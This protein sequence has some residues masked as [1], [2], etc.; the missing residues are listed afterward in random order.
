MATMKM[1]I[2]VDTGVDDA[3]AIM[4]ALSRP[5][6]EVVAITCVNGNVAID[7]VCRN[8]LRV[9]KVCN[10]LDIPV[11]KGAEKSILGEGERA[12]HYHGND[13]LG[14]A[15]NHEPVDITMIK[16]E[17][18]VNAL[19]RLV[20]ENPGEITLVALAPLTNIA[21]A[22]RLDPDFGS[23]LKEVFI[24]GGNIEGKHYVKCKSLHN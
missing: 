17:H 18:A 22:L 12:S 16:M 11:Y 20:N 1:I 23:K 19:L 8:T 4:L 5:E 3:S 21:L 10:R 24:M 13:G 15:Q 14:D 7:D 6:V 9:L 2:D